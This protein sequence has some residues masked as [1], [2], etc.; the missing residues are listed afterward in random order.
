M[1][2]P[3]RPRPIRARTIVAWI[4]AVLGGP[5][6]VAA[7]RAM[8]MLPTTGA[9]W[10][11]VAALGFTAAAIAAGTARWLVSALRSGSITTS[12]GGA[13]GAMLL[14]GTLTAVVSGAVD[15]PVLPL[16]AGL[17]AAS[18]GWLIAF[19]S[20]GSVGR[21]DRSIVALG[22]FL[23]FDAVVAASLFIT[24]TERGAPYV[25]GLAAAGFGAAAVLAAQR[26][27]TAA[28]ALALLAAG[29]AAL[30]LAR[31]GSVEGVVA[32]GPL[33]AAGALLAAEPPAAADGADAVPGNAPSPR[34][35][36]MAQDLGEGTLLF[37]GR[38]RLA[39]WNRAAVALLDLGTDPRDAPLTELLDPLLGGLAWT[40]MPSEAG[41]AIRSHATLEGEAPRELTLI[42]GEDGT[43]LL[44]IRDLSLER[45]ESTE[46]ARLTRELRG[47]IE[48]LLEARRTV[49][50]QR[51]ELERASTTDRLT[52]VASRR[53]TLERLALEVAQARRYA[54][55]VVVVVIDVDRFT[56]LNHRSGI[57]VGD[58]V[59]RELA[60]RL[61]LRMR[62][63]DAIGRIDGDCFCAIL[64]HTDERGAA[65]FAE[66]VLR[67]LATRPVMTEAGPITVTLSLGIALMAPG[68][69]LD[70]EELL[71]AA[72]E[73]LAS[74][75]RGGGN[76]IAFDRRHGLARL[77]ERRREEADQAS[78][79]DLDVG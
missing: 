69:E 68:M 10:L 9:A 15:A 54:H 43:A 19:A 32:L 44:V 77:E 64:P 50:L 47:T 24:W 79:P 21:L 18:V 2:L 48:E 41:E 70:P 38:G 8:P 31:P 14:A 23:A 26:R 22:A 20:H 1:T 30:V 66:S 57:E 63:A 76:R 34:L 17:A 36:E 75:R 5:I 65:D 6:F 52:G 35:P 72:D 4:T 12:I 39:D 13:A 78:E 73:A 40:T 49:E 59:L 37:D 16:L 55:P 27:A 29:C 25:A 61:R 60:L 71:A 58:A 42:H 11:P 56:E 3:R 67:R 46:A 51:A 7:L 62:A 74:A 45:D 28:G 33:I 53:A